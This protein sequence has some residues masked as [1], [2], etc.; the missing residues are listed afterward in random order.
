M[1]RPQKTADILAFSM[2]ITLLVV[3]FLARSPYR[4]T[5]P[6]RDSGIFLNIGSDILQGKVLYQQTWDNKQPLLYLFNAL[7]LWLGG[8]S[9]WGVWG[10]ELV[11]LAIIFLIAYVLLRA[12]L[13]PLATFLVIAIAFLAVFPFLGGNYSEEYSLVFQIGILGVLFGVY[14]PHRKRFSRPTA[15]L[16]IGALLGLVFCIKLTY[17]DIHLTVLLF[18]LFLAWIEKD[19]RVLGDILLV[20]LGF[21]LV[22][23]PVFLYFQA[24]GALRDYV[25]AAFLFNFYYSDL[26][27]LERIASILDK[28]RFVTSH[29]FFFLAASLWLGSLIVLC[30]KARHLFLGLMDHPYTKRL[31]LTAALVSFALFFLAQVRDKSSE[32]GYLQGMALAAGVGLGVLSLFLYLRKPGASPPAQNL[33]AALRAQCSAL[34]WHHP[35]FATFLFFGLVDFPLVLLTVS[36]GDK[37]YTHYF[38]TLFPAVLLLLAGGLA[39][40]Y[41]VAETPTHQVLVNS[42]LIGILVAG[43][44][45]PLRQVVIVLSEPSGQ[46]ERSLTAAYLKSVTTP[47]DTILVWGWESVIYFLAQR[48]SPTR[49]ALP[50]ALYLDTPYLDEYAGL[51]L[52]EVQAHPPAYIVDLMDARMPLIE[53]RPAE[54][55]LSGNRLDSPRLVDFLAFVCSHYEYNRRIQTINIYRLSGEQ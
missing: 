54:A 45:P 14:L 35:G 25:I 47:A 31:A 39:Y 46:D 34:D 30:L 42:L 49:F 17:L 44:F 40:L 48:D 16:A 22:N 43:S 27:I 5:V 1:Q 33:A 4:V 24:H 41:R 38:V 50:F 53:G 29:P 13:S 11:L 19:R 12:A 15:S 37:N 9:V 2:A 28:I 8:G 36:L 20:G 10:L 6:L 51:L 3:T 18:M 55:C 7:G 26:S 23:L 32:I 52:A 21:A